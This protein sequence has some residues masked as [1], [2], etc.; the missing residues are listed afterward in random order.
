MFDAFSALVFAAQ[1]CPVRAQAALD[2]AFAHH[3]LIPKPFMQFAGYSS[4][5]KRKPGPKG[6]SQELIQAIV[7]MK[8]R[9]PRLGCP[10]IAQQINKAFGVEIDKDLVRRVLAKYYRPTPGDSGPSWLSFLGHTKDSLQ[11]APVDHRLACRP[12]QE[13]GRSRC[14]GD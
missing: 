1:V 5:K 13:C 12:G 7:A 2:F 9:N 8:Q 3:A 4:G 14:P 11:V 6:P 10:R